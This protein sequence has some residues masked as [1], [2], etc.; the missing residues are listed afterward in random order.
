MAD[1][2]ISYSKSHVSLT[3][4]LAN[5]LE[6]KGLDVWWDT[7]LIAGKSFRE[8]IIQELKDCKAAIVIWTPDSIRSAYVVSEAE[9][10]R[11]AGKLIQVRTADVNP[12][13]LPPPFDTSHACLV[14]DRKGIFRSLSRVG[15]LPGDAAAAK[16]L[17]LPSE[18]DRPTIW[19]RSV[20][21]LLIGAA[22]TV[23]LVIGVLAAA[24]WPKETVA[25]A[26]AGIDLAAHSR[27][28]DPAAISE[29]SGVTAAMVANRFFDELNTGLHDSSIFDANVRL[30]RRG[31]MSKVDALN[32]LRKV[33][34]KY[35]K[36]NCRMESD[37]PTLKH[38]EF[39]RNGFRAMVQTECDFTD[40]TGVSTTERFPFEI[41]A[42]PGPRGNLLISGLWHSETMWF[43]QPRV[44]E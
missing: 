16:S 1:V 20:R 21:N 33:Q 36:I 39:A 12:A 19:R 7:E 37:K 5:E 29:A 23:L 25:P 24:N 44:R 43:W 3:R 6:A 11:V 2:F 10:A 28:I 17:R 30:G 13:E 31:L 40:L 14:D 42:T 18:D 32:E 26:G 27:G 41:E 15:L 38:A 35:T 4:D 22:A 34:F 8:R 9:R